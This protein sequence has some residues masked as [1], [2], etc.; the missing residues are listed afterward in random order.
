VFGWPQTLSLFLDEIAALDPSA[1]AGISG[2]RNVAM[3]VEEL[4]WDPEK[5]VGSIEVSVD[6][7][8]SRAIKGW[9]DK[10]FGA[11]KE[12]KRPKRHTTWGSGLIRPYA[13]QRS[14][15]TWSVGAA[16]GGIDIG[17]RLARVPPVR[18]GE[19]PLAE[20]SI[21][22]ERTLA[23]L[24]WSPTGKLIAARFG[25]VVRG[26]VEFREGGLSASFSLSRR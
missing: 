19:P 6:A 18:K 5:I 26:I 11:K 10:V 13:W 21:D 25:K 17:Q 8:A 9:L 15:S 3:E 14:G 20:L 23:D 1:E 12:H 22:I 2:L 4:S 16:L 7:G 24:G